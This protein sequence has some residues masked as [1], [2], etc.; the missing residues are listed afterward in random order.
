[1]SLQFAV[2]T[3]NDVWNDMY[4]LTV[5]SWHDKDHDHFTP[6]YDTCIKQEKEG[7]LFICTA[8]A[9]GEMVGFVI[10]GDYW[11]GSFLLSKYRESEPEMLKFADGLHEACCV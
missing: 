3:M 11:N 5:D 4:L 7:R 10:R 1:M 6:L 2:E 8:R 9:S